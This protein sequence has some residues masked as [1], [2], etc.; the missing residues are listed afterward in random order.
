MELCKTRGKADVTGVYDV[1]LSP[2]P[3][4]KHDMLC[5]RRESYF[6]NMYDMKAGWEL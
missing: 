6:T 2:T 5:L 1:K 4:G 3:T